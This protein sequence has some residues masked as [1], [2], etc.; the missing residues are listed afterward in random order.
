MAFTDRVVVVTG[1]ASG[2]GQATALGFSRQGARVALWDRNATGLAETKSRID[3]A[4]ES[5]QV[6]ALDITNQDQVNQM[7]DQVARTWGQIDI[8]VNAA[9][10]SQAGSTSR[11]SVLEVAEADWDQILDVNLMGTVFCAQAA[12]RHMMPQRR[13]RIVNV[14]SIAGALPRWHTAAYCVSKAGVRMFT[15]CLALELARYSIT[16]NAVAPGPT[17]TPML[18]SASEEGGDPQR[19]ERMIAGMPEIYRLGVPLGKL[20]QPEDVASA[21]QYLAS[22]EAHHLTGVILNVD[23]MAQ[24]S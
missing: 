14:A 18:G 13:G 10:I 11:G 6:Y 16:V 7:L 3:G 24:L 4:D 21:I 5:A 9:G 15:K 22:D 17:D 19:R 20:G 2:I 8:L 23:G 1:A 12:A